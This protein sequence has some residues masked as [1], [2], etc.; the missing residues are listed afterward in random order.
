MG[1]TRAMV[2]AM[3]PRLVKYGW[4]A[5]KIIS[6]SISK[7]FGYNRST[8]LS[9]M[10]RTKSLLDFGDKVIKAPVDTLISRSDM[11]EISFERARRYR[12]Y[13]I[14]KY[15]DV[16]TGYVKYKNLSFY[17]D[18]LNS[19]Q[20]WS[21]SFEAAKEESEYLPDTIISDIDIIAVE[22]NTRLGY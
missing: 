7:G 15:T 3:T 9:D 2:K 1:L 5:N 4:S 19:K 6:W 14:G 16:N 10:R 18:N 8:M 11:S 17:D 12:V 20:G 21:E 22:H 13:G